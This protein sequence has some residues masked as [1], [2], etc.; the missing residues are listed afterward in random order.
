MSAVWG[1]RVNLLEAGEVLQSGCGYMRVSACAPLSL[2]EQFASFPSGLGAQ[3]DLNATAMS[4]AVAM[5]ATTSTT[6]AAGNSSRLSEAADSQSLASQE[7]SE[8][9]GLSQD[10]QSAAVDSPGTRESATS[11]EALGSAPDAHAMQHE[12]A[13]LGTGDVIVMEPGSSASGDFR[14]PPFIAPNISGL[15]PDSYYAGELSWALEHSMHL[16]V[17]NCGMHAIAR[18]NRSS[19]PSVFGRTAQALSPAPANKFLR[20]RRYLARL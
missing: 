10:G 7:S 18:Q 17:S 5:S 14:Q 13:Y 12:A 11:D 8:Q 6:G 20:L 1:S 15:E 9:F 3:D 4:Q 2:M 19:G 16:F